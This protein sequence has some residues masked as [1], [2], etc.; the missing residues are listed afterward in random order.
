YQVSMG[1]FED[2]I[3]SYTE[4]LKAYGEVNAYQEIVKCMNE[5]LSNHSLRSQ[6]ELLFEKLKKVYNGI[7]SDKMN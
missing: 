3:I 7:A 4:S 1:L 5:I 6:S 2:G